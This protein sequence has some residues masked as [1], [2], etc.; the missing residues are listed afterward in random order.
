MS[1]EQTSARVAAIASRIL[2]GEEVSPEEVRA[3]AASALTQAGPGEGPGGGGVLWAEVVPWSSVVGTGVAL[4][5]GRDGPNVAIMTLLDVREDS[6][7]HPVAGA[8]HRQ[9][10]TEVAE[11]IAWRINR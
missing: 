8:R 10:A 5:A 11:W 4:R 2:R 7:R 1:S 6:G 9:R 3:V